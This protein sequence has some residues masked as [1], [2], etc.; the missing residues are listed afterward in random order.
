[1][2]FRPLK[3]SEVNEFRKMTRYLREMGKEKIVERI[4]T[5]SNE[6]NISNDILS[7][8][9]ASFSKHDFLSNFK[10]FYS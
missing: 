5:Y 4:D 10:I 7:S 2:Q 8:I 9:L 1:M 6:D 3:H